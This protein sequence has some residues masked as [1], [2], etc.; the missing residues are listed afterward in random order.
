MEKSRHK[1][2]DKGDLAL[3]KVMADLRQYG[4]LTCLPLSEHLPFDLIAV[5]PDMTTLVR[6]QVK[7]RSGTQY[8]TVL[9]EFKNNY[10]DSKKIYSK[11]VDFDE[12]DA[13]A[14]YI[15]DIDRAC[16]FRVADL[17]SN[18][19]SLTLRFEPPK[20]NQKKGVHLV[21][22]FL[23]PFIIAP[24]NHETVPLF[25]RG[26]SLEDEIAISKFASYLQEKH[27]YP[28]YPRSSFAPFDLIGVSSDT[29]SILRYRIGYERVE[30]TPHAD[31][32]VRYQAENDI[33]QF[34]VETETGNDIKICENLH[35]MT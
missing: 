11:P 32:F 7:Y 1:T 24:H 14:V 26:S 3:L 5:M 12:I 35:F 2:K 22:D 17:L 31:I 16:Y 9:V 15:P 23:N 4:I 18:A 6:I 33:P 8:G 25:R 13:Y 27:I 10:Y 30:H 29:K 21:K 34:L 28:F 20:N 19:S